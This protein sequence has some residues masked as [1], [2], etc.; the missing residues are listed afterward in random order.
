METSAPYPLE[1]LYEDIIGKAQRGLGLTDLQLMERSGLSMFAIQA[2]KEGEFHEESIAPLAAALEL[3]PAALGEI[4]LRQYAPRVS[5]VPGLL[6]INQPATLYPG[7]TVNLYLVWDEATKDA[8]LFD[9]GE[10]ATD[11]VEAVRRHSL[12]LKAIFL[13]HGHRDHQKALPDIQAALGNPPAFAHP[14]EGVAGAQAIDAGEQRQLGAL[15]LEVRST[16]GHSPAGLTYVVQGLEC[17][18][19]IVG[20]AIFAGSMGKVAAEKFGDAR[21]AIREQILSLDGATIVCPGHGC[22]STVGLER[23]HNPF[24]AEA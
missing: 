18:V 4:A 13:T 2:A 12:N 8:W 20:D 6:P 9:C 15:T 17:P 5:P 14:A 21:Q 22:L 10:D 7:A 3:E 24:F 11:V 1:D 19:V 23:K 16:P